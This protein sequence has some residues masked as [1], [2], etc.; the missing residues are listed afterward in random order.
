MNIH[1]MDLYL[2]CWTRSRNG[3][4]LTWTLS[5]FWCLHR[6]ADFIGYLFFVVSWSVFME[7]HLLNSWIFVFIQYPSIITL[8]CD[9]LDASTESIMVLNVWLCCAPEGQHCW[10]CRL[11]TLQAP[12]FPLICRIPHSAALTKRPTDYAVA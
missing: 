7:R 1:V 3:S 8:S 5:L 4:F 9:L 12:M 11:G 2:H 10:I 6:Y